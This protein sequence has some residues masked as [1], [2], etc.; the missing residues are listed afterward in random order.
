MNG[1]PAIFA[2][3]ILP[4]LLIAA[5]GFV[6]ARKLRA[7]VQTVTNVAFYALLPCLVFHM[8]VTSQVA[9]RQLSLMVI[10]G[11]LITIAMG[12]VGFLTARLMRLSR[13]ESSAF[14]L[15]VMFSNGG[16]YGLPVVAFAFGQE[17]LAYAT[18][19]FLTGAVLA[20]TVGSPF[21]EGE[22]WGGVENA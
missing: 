16:N 15:V 9:G 11:V 19:F 22:G 14:L 3:D 2:A 12:I 8:L 7:E 4:I 6:L 17:A 5:T 10:L 13:S 18:V 20:Y 1:L 21:V